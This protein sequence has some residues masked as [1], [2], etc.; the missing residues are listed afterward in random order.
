MVVLV[1]LEEVV[2]DDD[3]PFNHTILRLLQA[4]SVSQIILRPL[5]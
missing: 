2:E 4:V 3:I 5:S 1:D